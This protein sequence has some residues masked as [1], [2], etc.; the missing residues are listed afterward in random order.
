[1]PSRAAPLRPFTGNTK[2]GR[3]RQMTPGGW[4]QRSP[5]RGQLHQTNSL[6]LSK[7]NGNEKVVKGEGGE[8]HRLKRSKGNIT[9]Q[10]M[11][12]I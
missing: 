11:D 2:V 9:M 8:T 6:A 5:G 1:M 3:T 4:D 10:C 7:V 12:L